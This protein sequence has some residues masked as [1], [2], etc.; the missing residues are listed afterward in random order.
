MNYLLFDY[1]LYAFFRDYKKNYFILECYKFYSSFSEEVI[2][3]LFIFDLLYNK[4]NLY[5]L[6]IIKKIYRVFII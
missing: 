6:F 2:N 4:I 5:L 3:C 1:G